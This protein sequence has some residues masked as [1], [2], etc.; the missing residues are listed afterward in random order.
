[1]KNICRQ[2]GLDAFNFLPL[3][4]VFNLE[5]TEF[6]RDVAHFFR[7]FKGLQIFNLLR[8]RKDL[9]EAD[10]DTDSLFQKEQGLDTPLLSTQNNSSSLF[11]F[12]KQVLIYIHIYIYIYISRYI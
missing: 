6:K 2:Y 5:D 11:N 10:S 3:T 4:F 7:Y 8:K 1:M 12:N 9:Y